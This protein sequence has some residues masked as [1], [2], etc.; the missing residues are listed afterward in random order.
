MSSFNVGDEVI[1]SSP[2][3]EC[4]LHKGCVGTIVDIEPYGPS[5][6]LKVDT[7]G[8]DRWWTEDQFDLR[9]VT[10]ENK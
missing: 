1:M 7:L 4:Q 3:E 10:L 9:Y 6:I 8:L 2:C 5:F